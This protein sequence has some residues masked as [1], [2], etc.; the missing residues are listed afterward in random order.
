MNR[1]FEWVIRGDRSGPDSRCD[2]DLAND[3]RWAV[4]PTLGSLVPGWLLLIPRTPVLSVARLGEVERR[5]AFNLA[6]E[7]SEHL[8]AFGPQRLLLE[9]G[10]NRE[11]SNVGCGVDQAHLHVVVTSSDLFGIVLCDPDVHWEEVS[12]R[13]PWHG[14]SKRQEYYLISNFERSYVGFAAKS[15]SQ[16]FRRKIAQA[17][18]KSDCWDYRSWPHYEHAQRTIQ[19]FAGFT[20]SEAA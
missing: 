12:V 1:R 3:S 7:L 13:D 11:E 17:I 14:L 15:Q 5:A 10:P 2:I 20:I 8:I 6:S 19:Y 16:Y 18:G 9:H 4:V